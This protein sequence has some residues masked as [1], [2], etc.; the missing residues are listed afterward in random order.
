MIDD[1]QFSAA[2][3]G[4]KENYVYHEIC[5]WLPYNPQAIDDISNDMQIQGYR[6]DRPIVLFE[7]KILD[8]RHRY[9]AAL[10]VGVEPTYVNFNGTE[11]EAVD[12]VTSEN[13]NRRHLNNQEKE[14]FYVQ[15]AEALGVRRREDSLKQNTTVPSFDGTAPSAQDHADSL[16]VGRATIERWEKNRKDI[17]S[18]PVLSH[19]MVTPAGYKE[20]KTE[21]K[22]RRKKPR[23]PVVPPYNLNEAMGAVK[24]IA[25]MYGKQYE[26]STREA[27]QVLVDRVIE[28]HDFDSIGLSIA[29]DYAKWFLRF[30]EV[31]DFAEPEIK[32]FLNDKPDLKSVD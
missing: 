25:Q 2:V 15:R 29:R 27:S 21:L 12:Y 16:G 11:Q 8:G 31:L 10:K 1:N 26:G 20:A 18:D 7:G 22:R 32:A 5:L 14:F 17:K 19:K 30:K 13:V 6:T 24:G 3:Q 9:E 23:M 4:S 28:G